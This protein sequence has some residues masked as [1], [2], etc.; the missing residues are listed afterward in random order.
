MQRK[1]SDDPATTAE[2]LLGH[3]APARRL[4]PALTVVSHPDA[5]RIG[6][7]L[8]LEMLSTSGR[9]AALSRNAP[10]FSLPGGQEARPLGDLF[11]SRTPI[12]FDPGARGRLR[13]RVPEDGTTVRVEDEPL[14]GTWELT[15]EQLVAGVPLVLAERVVLLLHLAQLPEAPSVEHPGHGGPERGPEPGARARRSGWR[16]WTCRCSCAARRARARSWWPRPSTSTA[17]AVTGPSSASTWAPSPRSWPPRSSSV[18]QRGAFTGALRDRP[19]ASSAPRTAGTLFLDEVGEASP[20]VQVVLLRVLE[21]GEVYPVGGSTPVP[22][23]VRLVAATDANL[24]DAD[25][26]RGCSGRR[27]CTGWPATRCGCLRCASAARTLAR[28]SSTS[29]ARSWRRSA[30]PAACGPRIPRAEPWLPASLA[31]RLLRYS[32]PGNIRQLRNVTR[33]LVIGSRGLPQLRLDPRLEQ[34]LGS[35]SRHCQGAPASAPAP[36]WRRPSP[37]STWR[38]PPSR[39]RRSPGASPRRWTSRSCCRPCATARGT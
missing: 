39:T 20:E 17:P 2:H 37:R 5:E 35:P 10:E 21:T 30:S 8:L 31:V 26:T 11:L 33:Q 6:E 14:Q 12:E 16:T 25:R 4:V 3:Q 38:T 9:T 29:P 34:E 18:P 15:P 28:S 7:R 27:C 24:E 23:D 22:V 19:R 13:L 32:W 1:L 36:R